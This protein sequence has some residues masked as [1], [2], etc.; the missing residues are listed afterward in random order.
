MSCHVFCAAGAQAASG[1][2][3]KPKTEPLSSWFSFE[4]P[5]QTAAP[6]TPTPAVTLAPQVTSS[7]SAS[8]SA[9]HLYTCTVVV[10]YPAHCHVLL[11]R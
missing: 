3:D 7:P 1:V 5:A 8:L 4:E 2:E 6:P 9:C 11:E 10:I